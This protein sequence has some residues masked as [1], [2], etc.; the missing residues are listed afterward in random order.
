MYTTSRALRTLLLSL[1][2]T[3]ALPACTPSQCESDSDCFTGEFCNIGACQPTLATDV[4]EDD[5]DLDAGTDDAD[6]S[7]TD[8]DADADLDA[9]TNDSDL[10]TD[11]D[12]DADADPPAITALEAGQYHTCAIVDGALYCWGYNEKGQLGQALENLVQSDRPLLVPGL[13]SGVTAVALGND[14][15]CAVQHSA[16]KCF[17]SNSHG[18]LGRITANFDIPAPTPTAVSG[19]DRGV[20]DVAAGALHTCAIQNGALKCFGFNGLGAI[21]NSDT[22]GMA[23]DLNRVAEP[24]LVDALNQNVTR[25]RAGA[26]HTCAI[27]GDQLFCFGNNHQGQLGHDLNLNEE[28][29]NP[30]PGR[31]LGLSEL[32]TFD[33]G[34]DFNCTLRY[35]AARCWGHNVHGQAGH[36][37]GVNINFTPPT[38]TLYIVTGLSSEVTLIAT[39]YLHACALHQDVIKCWGNNASYR[40][41]H[42][43][44]SVYRPTEVAGLTDVTLLAAGSLHTCALAE[45]NV[46]CWG[47]ADQGQTTGSETTHI[48]Q[49]VIF[50]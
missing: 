11:L 21:G 12:A 43:D 48:P 45:G 10:D 34:Q 38:S 22:A 7:D 37:R 25:V 2:A 44:L 24:R 13:E 39:G 3:L 32:S 19:L 33:S 41:G 23:N 26:N 15:T 5:A 1:L 46:Y 49:R 8:L 35:G 31:V 29:P 42:P 30:D 17:G 27:Q 36:D 14:H 47:N 40:S 16:L 9:D 6:T 18:Q 4:D 50:P 20:S 28:T